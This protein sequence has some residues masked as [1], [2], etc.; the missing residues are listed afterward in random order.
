MRLR[1]SRD[2]ERPVSAVSRRVRVVLIVS[3]CVQAAWHAAAPRPIATAAALKAPPDMT[4][5]RLASIGEP[6]ALSQM[7]VLYLQAFDNQPGISVPFR[8]LDYAAVEEWL[9]RALQLD[10]DSQYPLM[11]A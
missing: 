5:L 8:N 6:I 11:M 9:A 2:S 4:A 3:L 1:W 7:L 10:P